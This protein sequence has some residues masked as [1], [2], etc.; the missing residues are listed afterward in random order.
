MLVSPSPAT[1]EGLLGNELMVW[2]IRDRYGSM[3]ASKSRKRRDLVTQTPTGNK[4]GFGRK[5]LTGVFA[6]LNRADEIGGE[7]RD[8]LVDRYERSQGLQQ[9]VKRIQ[10]LRGRE[11]QTVAERLSAK[12][13]KVAAVADAAPPPS[14]DQPK[15]ERPLGNTAIPAQI[16]GRSSCP[17]TGRAIRLFEDKKVDY[18]YIDFDEPEQAVFEPRLVAETHQN[19]IPYIYLRGEFIGGFNALDE[20]SRLGQMELAILS[21][22][23]RAGRAG[24]PAVAIA[25]RLNKDEVAPGEI[26]DPPLPSGAT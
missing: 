26:S 18:D 16:Y 7:V 4:S 14:Q 24:A 10:A 17:W 13:K 11:Y 20:L 22:E 1:G 6:V 15:V 5:M 25:P 12:A 2:K 23:E 19:T 3:F 21:A 9:Q 8:F